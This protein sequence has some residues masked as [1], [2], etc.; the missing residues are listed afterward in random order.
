MITPV[1]FLYMDGPPKSGAPRPNQG[2]AP[3]PSRRVCP[4][5]RAKV[6]PTF[7]YILLSAYG[8]QAMT[9]GGADERRHHF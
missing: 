8:P 5:K 4:K 2:T 3:R 9:L 6:V 7:L 1:A